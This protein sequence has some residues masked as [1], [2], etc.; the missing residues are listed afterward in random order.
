MTDSMTRTLVP[1]QGG[2]EVIINAMMTVGRDPA[3]DLVLTEG[4]A[5]R[6][7]ASV[8]PNNDGILVKDLGST[9][10]TF[11]NDQQV[12]EGAVAK[13]GDR[14]RFDTIVFNVKIQTAASAKPTTNAETIV[15]AEAIKP[16]AEKAPAPEQDIQTETPPEWAL[17]RNRSIEGTNI[18]SDSKIDAIALSSDKP[19]V[20]NEEVEVPTLIGQADPIK[21]MR[22]QMD[23]NSGNSI[24]EIGRSDKSHIMINHPSVSTNHAQIIHEG[25]RWKLVDSMSANGCFVNGTKGLTNYLSNGD[26]IKFGEIEC[27]FLLPKS[28]QKGSKMAPT[29]A[30]P[31]V[32]PP[33][34]DK[35]KSS[36]IKIGLISFIVTILAIGA[37]VLFLG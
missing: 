2:D 12:G 23:P 11:I 13:D 4:Q 1:E 32:H 30:N 24:W 9:N 35:P 15:N 18:L 27:V 34:A 16:A 14:L 26:T 22:F 21:S 3:C 28:M 37:V 17:E 29:Q 31:V 10:G 5:S 7:H 36:A 6:Q 33:E 19:I 20:D 8:S 25:A